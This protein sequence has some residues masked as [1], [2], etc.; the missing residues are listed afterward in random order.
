MPVVMRGHFGK[1]AMGN[2]HVHKLFRFKFKCTCILM[3]EKGK[4]GFKVFWS[5]LFIVVYFGRVSN[6][7]INGEEIMCVFLAII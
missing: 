5:F 3:V 4:Y 2:R 6:G 7:N 1:T